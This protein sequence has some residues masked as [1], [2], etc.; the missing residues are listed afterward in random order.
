VILLMVTGRRPASGSG[1]LGKMAVSFARAAAFDV[2]LRVERDAAYATELLHSKKIDELSLADRGLTH[3]IV[4]GVLRWQSSLD[5]TIAAQASQ[6]LRKLDREVLIA[7]RMAAYQLRF[8]DRVPANAAVNESVELV[9]RA[10]KRSAVP[11]ANAVLRKLAKAPKNETSGSVA[12]DFAHPEW[13]AKRWIGNYGQATAEAICRHDQQI[14]QTAIRLPFDPVRRKAV[15]V[16]LQRSGIG[17]EPGKLLH[18]ARRVTGGDVRHTAAFQRGE[19]WIQDEASQL[20]A[21]LAGGGERILDCCAAPG[22]K[23]AVL[24]ERNPQAKIVALELHAQR[25]KLLRER[26]KAANVAVETA[27]VTTYTSASFDCALADVPCSGTGTLARNPEIKWRLR[28]EDL[29]QLQVRQVAILRAALRQLAPGG[30]LV[31]ST[32]SLEPEEGEAVVEQALPSGVELLDCRAE[33][34]R[35]GAELVISDPESLV[36]GKYLR[37]LPGLQ[38]SDGFFAAV[39]RKQ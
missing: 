10:R 32:C 28:P 20:V 31:Y 14:P 7:L 27:D 9:K 21:P 2:L 24:A 29:G 35:I 37:T 25:A 6:P 1:W 18:V 26:V 34:A 19:V 12:E 4:M 5:G 17:L 23:T 16:E 11:F 38:D 39:L 36:R 13:I 22:G 33:L 15:E 3:E 8:L 30:R